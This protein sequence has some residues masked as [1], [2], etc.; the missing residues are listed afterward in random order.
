MPGAVILTTTLQAP[1]GCQLQTVADTPSLLQKE[2]DCGIKSMTA[3]ATASVSG[4]TFTASAQNLPSGEFNSPP[5]FF[6]FTTRAYLD[7]YFLTF[8]GAGAGTLVFDFGF[9]CANSN[10]SVDSGR[11]L[12]KVTNGSN[13]VQNN[14]A[15]FSCLP[16]SGPVGSPISIP[17]VFGDQIRV[18]LDTFPVIGGNAQ[19]L[20][21]FQTHSITATA[22]ILDS[23]GQEVVGGALVAIPEPG[24]ILPLGALLVVFVRRHRTGNRYG[25]C[26]APGL[27]Q[28]PRLR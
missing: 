5:Y 24:A 6:F 10:A 3:I 7:E 12:L 28:K 2:L 14:A 17:F 15:S 9:G 1:P 13:T 26:P 22:R 11:P 21:S 16:I 20:G 8:G 25:A 19:E 18:E 27:A 4:N 23:N